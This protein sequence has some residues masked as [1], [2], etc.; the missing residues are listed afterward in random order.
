MIRLSVAVRAIVVTGVVAAT[1]VVPGDTADG[2]GCGILRQWAAA[3]QRAGTTAS[4]LLIG[5]RP[6]CAGLPAWTGSE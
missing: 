4:V 3:D 2:P 1:I 5:P 6:V